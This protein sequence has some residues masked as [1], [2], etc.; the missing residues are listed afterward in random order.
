MKINF[1]QKNDHQIG[2]WMRQTKN[3]KW[4]F[5][6]SFLF[7]GY[8]LYLMHSYNPTPEEFNNIKMER[9][10]FTYYGD[11]YGSQAYL[12]NKPIYCVVS[13]AGIGRSCPE[14]F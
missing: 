10:V 3:F 14:K 11:S 7:F 5:T 1:E 9:G 4:I 2:W 6:L 12:N 13:Y 8:Q